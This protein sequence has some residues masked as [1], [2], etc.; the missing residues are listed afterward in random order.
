MVDMDLIYLLKRLWGMQPLR[1]SASIASMGVAGVLEGV[2]VASLAP[3]LQLMG[4]TSGQPATPTDAVGALSAGILGAFDLPFTLATSLLVTLVFITASQL[5]NL[6]HARLLSSSVAKLQVTL[7]T[8]L[9]QDLIAADWPFFVRQKSSDLATTV[10]SLTMRAGEAYRTVVQLIGTAL[11]VVFYL[12]LATRISLALTVII[13]LG[14]AAI[15]L[16]LRRRA[17]RGRMIGEA[18]NETDFDIWS[19]ASE[20]LAAAKT[21]KAYSLEAKATN[22]LGQIARRF[23]DLQYQLEMNLS[24]L[25]YLFELI[26]TLAVLIGIFVGV[27]YLQLSVSSL[28]VF[29]LVFYRVSP[30]ISAMQ[31]L[32]SQ[33]LS[34]V[35]AMRAVE[36]LDEGALRAREPSGDDAV[37]PLERAVALEDVDFEY[38]PDACVLEAVSLAIPRGQ[39][40]AIVGPSGS[41]KT[42]IVDLI[43]GLLTP[44]RGAVRVDDAPLSDLDLAAWRSR[45]GY[46][47]QDGSLF[48]DTVAANIRLGRISATD[49]EIVEAA[50][51]AFADEFIQDLPDGY[52]TVVGDRGVRLSGGQ[53]QRI[54]LARA[55]VRK[56]EI[57]VLDEA[58]SALDA[59]SEEKILQA[60]DRL[61]RR[62]TIVIV[63]HRLATVRGADTIHFLEKGRIVESGSWSELVSSGGRFAQMQAQ[64]DLTPQA[65]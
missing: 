25:R 53:R 34:N 65:D 64:Q 13:G 17:E 18:I 49:A 52:D 44:T 59:E 46:V 3:L 47:A 37:L 23:G 14:G 39:T 30:R 51:L 28:V 10:V 11:V 42:T 33:T 27:T 16:V 62:T 29:L 8:K 54:A 22:G 35:P 58:T 63:T 9:Y 45:I 55:L 57:L 50:R 41:G 5:A 6:G 2:A 38:G 40:T 31:G 1:L 24:T 48:H 32:Q 56:P 19:D 26:S 12:V 21:L 7:R 15:V 60:V 61:A 36:E 20:H 4:Q 43:L